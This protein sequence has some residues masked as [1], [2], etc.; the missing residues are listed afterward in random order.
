[1]SA[2]RTSPNLRDTERATTN[3]GLPAPFTQA[4]IQAL[5]RVVAAGLSYGLCPRWVSRE[6]RQ[7][8]K[9]SSGLPSPTKA[10]VRVRGD[11]DRPQG[12]HGTKSRP[13]PGPHQVYGFLTT[14]VVEPIHAKAMPVILT[15]GEERD[16]WMRAAWDEGMPLQ[17]P[18][19][20]LQNRGPRQIAGR[21]GRC[22][23][24]VEAQWASF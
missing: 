5:L 8:R 6:L 12:D 11:L 23:K 10:P 1:M 21:S 16:A 4:A 9:T 3:V 18:S 2:W 7:A 17:R 19:P 24:Y 15:I 20:R 14:A 13:I 22:M